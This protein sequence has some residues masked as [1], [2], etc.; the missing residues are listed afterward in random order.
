MSDLPPPLPESTGQPEQSELPTAVQTIDEFGNPFEVSDFKDASFLNGM[1][2]TLIVTLILSEQLQEFHRVGAKQ[3]EIFRWGS[4][5]RPGHSVRLFGQ[6]LFC[7]RT[8][9]SATEY[10]ES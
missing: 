4:D 1:F 10:K 6:A 7:R 2:I 8:E 3:I 9:T 5:R